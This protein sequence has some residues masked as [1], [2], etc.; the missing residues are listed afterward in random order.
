[1]KLIV[2]SSESDVNY[3]KELISWMFNEGLQYFHLR[4]PNYK[5]EELK[6]Y[7][8]MF[9]DSEL[10]KMM[11]H[12]HLTLT[13]EYPIKG[14]SLNTKNRGQLSE[15][16]NDGL[17]HSISCHSFYELDQD[18]G[19][20]FHYKFISP[21]FD[22][23]SKANYS[24]KYSQDEIGKQLQVR[25]NFDIVALGGISIHNI[26]TCQFLGF[27]GVAVLGSLWQSKNFKQT[28]IKIK[29]LCQN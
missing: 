27:D 4:K 29:E 25:R 14:I 10:N 7:L 11:L 18:E 24:S 21:I 12:E 17:L 1:V 5:R 9:N 16:K 22:S 2:F 26:S 19:Y 3:E 28:F 8:D 13:N 23:I 15:L 20:N 6:K